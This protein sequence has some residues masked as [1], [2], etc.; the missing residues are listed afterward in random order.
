MGVWLRNKTA[1]VVCI[2]D[3]DVLPLQDV[4]VSEATA[5]K[6]DKKPGVTQI[7]ERTDAAKAREFSKGPESG[8]LLGGQP[9]GSIAPVPHAAAKQDLSRMSENDAIKTINLETDEKTLRAYQALPDVPEKIKIAI[10]ARLAKIAPPPP[11]G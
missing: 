5:A 9:S 11:K 6:L 2:E 3:K 10:A 8:G 4:E 7:F 1:R